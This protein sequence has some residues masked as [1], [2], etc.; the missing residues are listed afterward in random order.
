MAAPALIAILTPASIPRGHMN[1][2]IRTSM[3]EL[4]RR[5][6]DGIHIRLLWSEP[7][8]QLWVTVVD[9][10]TGAAFG[11]G[12]RGHERAL[13]VFRHPYAYAASHGIDTRPHV[14]GNAATALGAAA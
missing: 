5:V 4:H 14:V 12:V 8:G 1:A 13:D 10:K 7:T 2:E 6:D 3:R 9:T 11:L